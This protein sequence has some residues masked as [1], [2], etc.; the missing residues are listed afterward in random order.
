MSQKKISDEWNRTRIAL[1]FDKVY[2]FYSLKDTGI[3]DLLHAGIPSIVVRDQAR[4]YDV[5]QTDQY[6]ERTIEVNKQ[7]LDYT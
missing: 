3:T 4:H 1:K 5:S 6:A 2:Q 7:I